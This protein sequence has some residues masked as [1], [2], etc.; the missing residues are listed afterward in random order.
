MKVWQH[1]NAAPVNR[2]GTSFG[3]LSCDSSPKP[4]VVMG[5]GLNESAVFDIS[6]GKCRHCFRVLDPSLSY[7]DKLSLPAQFTSLPTL[8]EIHLS[9]DLGKRVKGIHKTVES[10]INTRV[11][12]PQPC[13][14]SFTGRVGSSGTNYLV[15]GGTDGYLRYWDFSHPSKCFTIS[16]LR[17]SQPRPIYESLEAA[18][19]KIILCRQ[20]PIPKSD[21]IASA[22]L[23]KLNNRGVVRPESRHRDAIMDVKKLEFPMKGF[24]SC[25][26]DGLIKFWR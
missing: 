18:S 22:S 5:C 6:S 20:V 17:Y 13:I 8:N 9:S 15:T 11:A 21:E 16:G 12:P 10:V 3:A 19:G 23:P 4:Y 25:S 1:S 2:L 24:I 14:Q 7:V 26:R